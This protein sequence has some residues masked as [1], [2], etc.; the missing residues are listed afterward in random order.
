MTIDTGIAIAVVSNQ[1][2]QLYRSLRQR[3]D[4]EGHILNEAGCAN[5]TRSSHTGEDSRADCPVLSINLRIFRKLSRDIQ[6]EL[7]ETSLDIV[8]LL[9]KLFVGDTFGLN[10]YRRQV[11]IVS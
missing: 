3:L 4:R 7:R 9:Q 8:Y 1:F 2:L 5:G 11:V 10:E 6:A